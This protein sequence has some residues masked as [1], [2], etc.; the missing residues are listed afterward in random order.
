[1]NFKN[2][3]WKEDFFCSNNCFNCILL[4]ILKYAHDI[5]NNGFPPGVL[6][7]MMQFSVASWRVLN[8]KNFA[9]VEQCV[10]TRRK[11][12]DYILDEAKKNSQEW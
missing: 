11:F 9:A 8:E 12:T 2:G 1:L 10:E 6:M 5:I 7:P 3:N 4:V